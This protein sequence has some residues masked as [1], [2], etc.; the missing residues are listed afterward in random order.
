MQSLN[1]GVMWQSVNSWQCADVEVK[2]QA[3][4]FTH[5]LPARLPALPVWKSL[6]YRP[7]IHKKHPMYGALKH[8]TYGT[9]EHSHLIMRDL[10]G[11]RGK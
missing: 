7:E 6:P 4:R 2:G 5:S 9:L 1:W 10:K 11:L 8:P 3:H